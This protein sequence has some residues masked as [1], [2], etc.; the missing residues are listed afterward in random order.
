MKT[1][2]YKTLY[3]HLKDGNTMRYGETSSWWDWEMSDKGVVVK[4]KNGRWI[5]FINVDS[6]VAVEME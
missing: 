2:E 1:M 5:A 6:I 3:I 4:D